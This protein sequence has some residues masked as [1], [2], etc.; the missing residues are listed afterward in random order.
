MQLKWSDE[1]SLR[2][3]A[4]EGLIGDSLERVDQNDALLH[5]LLVHKAELE[6]QNEALRDAQ[7]E[8]VALHARYKAFFDDAPTAYVVLD[9]GSRITAVN[10]RAARMLGGTPRALLG[11]RL[12]RHLEPEEAV[13]FER[14]R[15]DVT[16]SQAGL[17]AERGKHIRVA[18]HGG[19]RNLH[20]DIST[21]LEM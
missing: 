12:T 21:I 8:I 20:R 3:L 7:L 11:V 5:E 17:S 16:E 6:M 18:R 4:E 1:A 2:R 10:D 13:P 9:D 15:R 19:I 14:Y